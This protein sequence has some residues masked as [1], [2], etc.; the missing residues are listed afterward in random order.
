M[1]DCAYTEDGKYFSI[2][3]QDGRLRIW[4]TETN[5][6]KQ[7][8]T[9]DL[10][11]SSPLT[12][13]NWITLKNTAKSQANF[14]VT[15]SKQL[16]LWCLHNGS[17]TLLRNMGHSNATRAIL[18]L[19]CAQD[20]C[21]IIEGS[22]NERLLAF[23]DVTITPDHIPNEQV[24]GESSIPKKQRKKS[25]SEAES[26]TTP[27]YNFTLEDSPSNLDVNIRNVD[28]GTK[29]CLA[30]STKSGV[31]HY[32]GHMLN[33]ASTKPIK[34]SVTMKV[35][36]KDGKVM[37]LHCCKLANEQD[38]GEMIIGYEVTPVRFMFERVIPDTRHK[39][40]VL[41]RA[42]PSLEATKKK[43][44]KEDA[45]K[46]KSLK[47]EEQ[48]VTYIE[49]AGGVI[50]KRAAPGASVEVPMEVRLANL[51]LDTKTRGQS[52]V[53]QNLTKLLVQGLHSKDK[54]LILTVLQKDD[55]AVAE[56]TVSGLPGEYI[57]KLLEQL[58]DLAARKTSQCSTVCTWLKALLRC[59]A[60]FLLA[61]L[62]TPATGE[63]LAKIL[64]VLTQRSSPPP[65][66][67]R[68]SGGVVSVSP[69]SWVRIGYLMKK[70]W[71]NEGEGSCGLMN[72]NGLPELSRTGQNPTEKTVTSRLRSHLC[73]LLN[74][75]GRLEL[76]TAQRA[77]PLQ[78]DDQPLLDY[79]DSSSSEEDITEQAQS[80][81]ESWSENFE[82]DD[83]ASDE[84]M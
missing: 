35:A 21:C 22:D 60:A 26:I 64:A 52:A 33:G 83:Q 67:T 43:K 25:I 11:L 38:S 10:H 40:Q 68:D 81:P 65:M 48:R 57:P 70:Q 7:E 28:G 75:R 17:A 34:P 19:A 74:L 4:D 39:S 13:L 2:L 61:T 78:Y 47:T 36:T 1:A 77:A 42:D 66:N 44:R 31:V 54:T 45:K 3:S 80:E 18:T 55:P 72:E 30:A 49:P 16:R 58:T 71:A 15:A 14:L 12:C 8:Y 37:P 76:A 5:T 56:R 41:V 73:Q 53:S 63:Q 84:N 62:H 32:F 50:R 23:W 9:P 69:A 79:N 24:N 20:K 29:L 59:H 51:E 82:S 6:L 46:E 27:I